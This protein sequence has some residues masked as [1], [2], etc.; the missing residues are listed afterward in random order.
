M[1][2][3]VPERQNKTVMNY[4]LSGYN[5]LNPLEADFVVEYMQSGDAGKAYSKAFG[6]PYDKSCLDYGKA[7]LAKAPIKK[8]VNRQI[9]S[10]VNVALATDDT[11]VSEM[12]DAATFDVKDLYDENGNMKPINELPS[13]ITKF[14]KGIS[15]KSV[16]ERMGR[17]V[18]EQGEIVNISFVDKIKA[19]EA[20]F[21]YKNLMKKTIN[22]II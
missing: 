13:S 22:R 14:I 16:S 17:E 15:V 8:A 12:I 4:D 2:D 1:G 6:V 5:G 18:I 7:L 19:I 3:L 11:I 9:A 10:R 20:L 21:H